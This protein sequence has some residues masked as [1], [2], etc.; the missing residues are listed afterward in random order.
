MLAV[1]LFGIKTKGP[2]APD[3]SL[4]G[5]RPA[6]YVFSAH[7]QNAMAKIKHAPKVVELE[8]AGE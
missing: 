7:V 1:E 3:L 4:E 2:M 6:E 8:D 5:Q